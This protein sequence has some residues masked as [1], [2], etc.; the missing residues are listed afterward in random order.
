[1]LGH[2]W[3]V[4]ALNPKGITF[5]VAF[6]PQFL[7]PKADFWTQMLIFEATFIGL[8]FANALGYALIASRARSVVSNPRAIGLF[9]KAGGTLLVG[10]GIATV[11]MRSG[12]H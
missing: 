3:L 11:A 12:S 4:T 8:A 5:F 6:L 10:A 9:N 2:A 1:M 7:D